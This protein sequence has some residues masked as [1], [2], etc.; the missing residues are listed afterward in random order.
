MKK[1]HHFLLCTVVLTCTTSYLFAEK[2]N[3][4]TATQVAKNFYYETTAA[5]GVEYDKIFISEL[6]DVQRDG[7]SVYYAFN[8]V[9]GGFVIVS[10]DD[11]YTPVIGYNTEGVYSE[12]DAPENWRWL[13]NEYADMIV[14]GREQKLATNSEYAEKWQRLTTDDPS[15][16][17]GN[18]AVVVPPLCSAQWN[19]SFPYNYYAP[20]DSQGPGGRAYAGCVATAMSIIMHYWRWPLQGTGSHSYQPDNWF[21]PGSNYPQQTANFEE[22]KY[23]YETMANSIRTGL[24]NP[25]ALL[26]YH[27]GVAV[28]MMYC[29]SGSGAYS[30]DVPNAIKTHFKYDNSAAIYGKEQMSDQ[31]WKEMLKTDL[32]KKFPMYNSGCSNSGCHA[33]VCDGYT[34]DDLFHYNFGWGGAQNGYYTVN[35]VNGFYSAQ[36]IIINYIPDTNQYPYECQEFTLLPFSEGNIADCSGPVHNYSPGITASWLIDPDAGGDLSEKTIMITWEKFDLA[37]DD[38]IR[39][40]DGEN[41]ECP[42]LAEY[43]AGSQPQEINSTAPKVFIR[44][45][46]APTSETAQ[47]FLL[48]FQVIPVKHCNLDEITVFTEQEGTFH[49]GSGENYHYP[50]QTLC[51]WRIEPENAAN[52]TITFNYFETE[53]KNDVLKIY[54]AKNIKLIAS[55]SGIYEG[56]NLPVV[57]VPSGKAMISF[58]SNY[59]INAKGFEINYKATAVAIEEQNQAVETLTVFPNPTS[60]NLN[61]SFFTQN[62]DNINIEIYNT[63]G[64][65]IYHEYLPNF[66]GNYHKTINTESLSKGVYFLKVT[67]LKGVSVKKIIVQ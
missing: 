60:N 30:H 53:E 26:M 19:Q 5:K 15:L 33:F 11:L 49:D 54:D 8:F 6:F 14:F 34:D 7:S 40:Y 35:N 63:I 16:L 46:T 47:G 18:R 59:S 20:L 29:H 10:A 31:Q 24:N 55:L 32:D 1:F 39:I 4:Q 58:S 62:N 65:N 27:C 2:V 44:F 61:L 3:R 13:M 50:N 37:Q 45:T 12:T 64:Q 23:I 38:Y 28:N 57:T 42:L 41:E 17:R 25:V 67:S 9:G 22:T 36:S 52:L 66:V 21:C 48:N 43:T 56:N 51:R